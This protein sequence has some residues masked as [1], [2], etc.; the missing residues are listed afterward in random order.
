MAGSNETTLENFID[1][2]NDQQLTDLMNLFCDDSGK[3][4]HKVPT[5][6]LTNRQGPQ[7]RE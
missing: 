2:I 7:I 1:A 3:G 6:G 4:N 5:V